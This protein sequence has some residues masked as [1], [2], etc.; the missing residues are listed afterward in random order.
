[1]Y[2]EE[3]IKNRIYQKKQKT[4]PKTVYRCDL[5]NREKLQGLKLY[6]LNTCMQWGYCQSIKH[7]GVFI[8]Y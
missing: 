8:I 6:I 5:K 3:Q 4:L 7:L 2:T 1:M